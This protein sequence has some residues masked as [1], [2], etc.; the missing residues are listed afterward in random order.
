MTDFAALQR[1]VAA[2]TAVSGGAFITFSIPDPLD[3]KTWNFTPH[4]SATKDQVAAATVV[5]MAIDPTKLAPVVDTL[6]A[7]IAALEAKA[8]IVKAPAVPSA[9]QKK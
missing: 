7:R 3:P 2:I 5:C 9:T 6:E 4:P 1:V 8:G